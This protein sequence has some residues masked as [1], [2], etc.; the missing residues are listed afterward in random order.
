MPPLKRSQS[1][2]SVFTTV[3]MYGVRKGKYQRALG[4]VNVFI[5]VSSLVM[6]ILGFLFMK[7]YHM[8]KIYAP[9]NEK[10]REG[11]TKPNGLEDLENFGMLPWLLISI[12]FATFVLATLGFLF[13]AI[14]SK[15]P[16]MV[17]SILLGLLVLFQFY[18]I[19]VTFNANAFID[20]SRQENA[21]EDR[22]QRQGTELYL[23]DETFRSRW[24]IIQHNLRCC[25]FTKILGEEWRHL[26]LDGYKKLSN[27][28]GNRCFP[29]SCCVS[30]EDFSGLCK[31][32]PKHQQ[33][34]A[35]ICKKSST[36]KDLEQKEVKQ[37]NVHGCAQVLEEM[38]KKTLPNVFFFIEINGG[39]TI[40]IEVV[41]I[42][43]S[44]AF[45]AQITRRS[46]RGH[47]GMEMH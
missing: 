18:F 37:L 12:G 17:Y 27:A 26:G 38:Y 8:D 7:V 11:R 14:E 34:N 25:G 43:L 28:T 19:Y 24:N 46:K 23:N 2:A 10:D 22:F 41:A 33:I 15:P 47:P 1:S 35:E 9:S 32:Q 21:I 31:K 29:E 39:L 13:S 5:M 40:L 42:A 3:S 30:P 20:K 36:V 16:L 4:I 44:S 45:V 6:T